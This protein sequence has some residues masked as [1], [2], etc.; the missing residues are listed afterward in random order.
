M[1]ETFEI[2][3]DSGAVIGLARRSEC[4]G[5][6]ALVHRTAH[7]VVVSRTGE[8]L[9]QKR[10]RHKDIQPGKWDTAVGGHLA[11]GETYEQAACREM[12]EE[13]G[14]EPDGPLTHLFDT[15]I[16]NEI[17]SENVRVFR[18][19]TDGPF[20]VDEAEI[21]AVRFWVK[22]DLDAALGTG[23][24]TPILEAEIGELR[25]RGFLD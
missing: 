22:S 11:V 23:I 12:M 17:E 13:I 2:V 1:S 15:H 8:L 18:A 21:D 4:H 14:V 24:F 16:R 20:V 9:L 19:V 3:D 5:N 25:R 10:S 7:V 6:P